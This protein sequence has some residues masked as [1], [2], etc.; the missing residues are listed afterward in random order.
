MSLS[1][2]ERKKS[3]LKEKTDFNANVH[4]KAIVAFYVSPRF[5][6]MV[7]NK[8]QNH[9]SI[10]IILQSGQLFVLVHERILKLQIA[11]ENNPTIS[12]IHAELDRLVN[13]HLGEADDNEIIRN[14]LAEYIR[15][16]FSHGAII[17]GANAVDEYRNIIAV[18]RP[19]LAHAVNNLT[20]Q[21]VFIWNRH[22]NNTINFERA[23]NAMRFALALIN[24]HLGMYHYVRGL[25]N[26]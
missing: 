25:I 4:L 22:Y 11:F 10:D 2:I 1:C 12:S 8:G 16:A 21:D 5:A 19:E 17:I 14:H 6:E 7:N 3:A 9:H 20:E 26:I 23:Y 24:I 13:Q 18:I 15:N